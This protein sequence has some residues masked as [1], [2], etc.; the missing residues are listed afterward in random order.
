[1]VSSLF[2]YEREKKR[3]NELPI[4]P[5]NLQFFQYLECYYCFEYGTVINVYTERTVI[6]NCHVIII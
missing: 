3:K 2:K 5:I 1:M 6:E 4:Y